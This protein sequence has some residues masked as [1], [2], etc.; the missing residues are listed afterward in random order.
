MNPDNTTDLTPFTMDLTFDES[1]RRAEVVA[2]L[3]PEWD[4]VEALRGEDEAYA[5]LYSGLDAEQ[6][7]TYDMLVAAGVLPGE[8]P[9]R[10]A[11]H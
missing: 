7:R 8:E 4:P 1:R 2:A 10:A 5:L 11:A 6:Q 9:G 3:G